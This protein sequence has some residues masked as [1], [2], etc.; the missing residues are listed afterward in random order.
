MEA[1][2]PTSQPLTTKYLRRIGVGEL[3]AR[4]SP[5]DPGYDPATLEGHLEQSAH[6]M[7]ILKLPAAGVAMFWLCR[8]LSIG[9]LGA[10]NLR[11]ETYAD[12]LGKKGLAVYRTLAEVEWTKVPEIGP[13]RDDPASVATEPRVLHR[14]EVALENH[15]CLARRNVPD[16]GVVVA[17]RGDHPRAVGGEAR[18]RDPALVTL[19][20]PRATV[21]GKDDIGALDRRRRP[22]GTFGGTRA[23]AN[24]LRAKLGPRCGVENMRESAARLRP[25]DPAG[26]HRRC[27]G[28]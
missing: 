14:S 25:H 18:R 3:P 27:G 16:A 7:S 10:F 15:E 19:E 8:T 28:R 1:P 5:F 22:R 12:A 26:R 17:T 20:D 4:T 2:T 21:R 24:R 23:C 13:G 11:Q 9:A 6:L